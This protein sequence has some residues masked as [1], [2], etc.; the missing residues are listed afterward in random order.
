MKPCTTTLQC[1]SLLNQV[2]NRIRYVH[3]SLK[4]EKAYLYG[5]RFFIRWIA[6]QTGSMRHLRSTAVAKME[7]FLP[8]L[9]K[10]HK[11]SAP[12]HNQALGA[13]MFFTELNWT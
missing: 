9:P 7:A 6:A 1:T 3:Y 4:T 8:V 13:V 12:T 2:P 5:I 10:E 11:A